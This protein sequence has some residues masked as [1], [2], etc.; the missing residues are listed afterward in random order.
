M[1]IRWQ[2]RAPRNVYGD[3]AD[4]IDN[5]YLL[6]T[7]RPLPHFRIMERMVLER[8]P[9]LF[10]RQ[11]LWFVIVNPD[12]Q[13]SMN[14]KFCLTALS[15]FA[16][17]G[18]FAG[19]LSA[20]GMRTADLGIEVT[21][22]TPLSVTN[23]LPR[24]ITVNASFTANQAMLQM[25]APSTSAN[26]NLYLSNDAAFDPA[27][28]RLIA[29]TS[30]VLTKGQTRSILVPTRVSPRMQGTG[31][32][33]IARIV[34]GYRLNDPVLANNTAASSLILDQTNSV[35][36]TLLHNNDGESK[37]NP[38][39]LNGKEYGGVARFAT[40]VTQQKEW[41]TNMTDGYL[42]VSSGDN[43]LASS[44]F[45][46][47]LAT[48]FNPNVDDVFYDAIALDLL[49]YDSIALGN[50]D[51]DFG[52]DVL[53][54]MI[55]SFPSMMPPPYL[56]ANMDFSAEPN[57]QA[58]VDAGII[59]GSAIV[60]V[61]PGVEV[62]VISAIFPRLATISS[63]RLAK[64]IDANMDGD[65]T[66]D[67][68]RIIV[69]NE[70][71][72][73]KGMGINKIVIISHLQGISEELALIPQLTD[74]DVVVAG[75]GSEVLT[76]TPAMIVP[77]ET[78][79]GP[80]PLVSRNRSGQFVPVVTTSGDYRYLGKLVLTFDSAGKLL[81]F[82]GNP[83]RIDDSLAADPVVQSMVVDPVNQFIADLATTI[84]GTS[85][86]ALDGVRNS[87]RTK[88]T[89]LGNLIADAYIHSAEKFAAATN[90]SFPNLIAFTNGGGIRNNTVIPAGNISLKTVND[91]LPFSNF[92]VIVPEVTPAKLKELLENAV[93][94][95]PGEGGQFAQIGGFKFTFN[96]S[97]TAQTFTGSG[98]AI[99]ITT[100]GT[101][102]V[103]VWL[104]DGTMLI[105]DGMVVDG[106]PNVTV[107]TVDFLATGGDGY[108]FQGLP[109]LSTGEFYKFSLSNYILEANGLNGVISTADY[110]AAGEGRIVKLP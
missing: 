95:A 99:T 3:Y 20:Q 29:S 34:P 71:D 17:L 19:S 92:I 49:G 81:S 1:A 51:F 54:A 2:L 25:D 15:A 31:L 104:D 80:Y 102:I 50:H 22:F 101:R 28:D 63:P 30:T 42:F 79:S 85:E 32:Y 73:L 37:V 58:L 108:P 4:S 77:G 82:N 47:S 76:N 93:R 11:V 8:M 33:I 24:T 91:I 78:V 38:T 100:P 53:A 68:V 39:L 43:F 107:A 12:T 7:Q 75:G 5:R 46:A 94:S 72:A 66:L 55:S 70:I 87:V 106:A 26:I 27:A 90:T 89:N 74:I 60:E 105:E 18:L 52:P 64:V 36:I 65:L 48:F 14:R 59:G 45:D 98:A 96:T 41:A 56:S 109:F 86:V 13:S 69:Q 35:V 84:V 40:A 10:L 16:G 21:G 44:A 88:E 23:P 57:L 110:P 9:A 103:D 83:I 62:G 6:F 61:A 67:D 97:G